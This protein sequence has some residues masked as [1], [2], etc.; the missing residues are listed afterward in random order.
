MGVE[1][2]EDEYVIGD[3][4]EGD[5]VGFVSSQLG[6]T[7]GDV[8]VDEG[9]GATLREGEDNALVFQDVVV[10]EKWDG[11]EV[12]EGDGVVDEDEEAATAIWVRAVTANGGVVGKRW[13]GGGGGQ[14]GL[15]DA[16]C[17]DVVGV[18]EI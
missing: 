8:N 11:V 14:L 9:E 7:R 15:L 6:R 18:E 10:R 17:Q 13:E 2:P 5:E 16:G 3:S 1:V 12:S 4:K